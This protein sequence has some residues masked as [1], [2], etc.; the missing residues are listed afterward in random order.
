MATNPN[1]INLTTSYKL[2]LDNT[3]GVY[4]RDDATIA[5]G[6][7]LPSSIER[8]DVYLNDQGRWVRDKVTEV[9]V[10]KTGPKVRE[11]SSIKEYGRRVKEYNSK[12]VKA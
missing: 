12:L 4:S 2:D 6:S 3:Q 8:T 7:T 1:I 11:E 10:F 5:V 9:N